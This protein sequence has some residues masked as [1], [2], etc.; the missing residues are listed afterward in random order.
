MVVSCLTVII[1]RA[2]NSTLCV[3]CEY[4]K[5]GAVFNTNL[6]LLLYCPETYFNS[7]ISRSVLGPSWHISPELEVAE[8]IQVS[9]DY[10]DIDSSQCWWN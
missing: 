10:V 8:V 2:C 6:L 3:C 1:A 4:S 9:S 5:Q 7:I